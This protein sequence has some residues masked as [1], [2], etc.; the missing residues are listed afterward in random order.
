MGKT[1]KERTTVVVGMGK[2]RIYVGFKEDEYPRFQD[3]RH[4]KVVRLLALRRSAF[5][6][7]ELFLLLISVR[8]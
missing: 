1:G 8:I 5:T 6:I 4:M 7:Q 3:Y 2:T